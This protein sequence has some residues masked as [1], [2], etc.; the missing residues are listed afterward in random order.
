M[1]EDKVT[2]ARKI[3]PVYYLPYDRLQPRKDAYAMA[4]T[5]IDMGYKFNPLG[6]SCQT[7]PAI[8]RGA[9]SGSFHIGVAEAGSFNVNRGYSKRAFSNIDDVMAYL[10]SEAKKFKAANAKIAAK[11]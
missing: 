2:A 11:K 4:N 5:N 8:D 6:D 7:E 1:G 10:Q 3:P 9:F